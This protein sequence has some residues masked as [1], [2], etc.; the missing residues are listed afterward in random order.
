MNGLFSTLVG[1]IKHTME[2]VLDR[3]KKKALEKSRSEIDPNI[4]FS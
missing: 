3:A 1:K 2:H 4:I